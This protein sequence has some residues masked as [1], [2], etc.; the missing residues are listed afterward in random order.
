MQD[1]GSM[2]I[3]PLDLMSAIIKG[4]LDPSNVSSSSSNAAAAV[5]LENRQFLMLLTTSVAVL[6]GCFVVFIWR[7]S[8]SPKAKPLEPPKRVIEKLPEIEVDDG[9]KKVTIFFGTQTGTAEGFAKAIAEE[10]KAR[11]DKAT[12]RVVDMDDY[13]A[14]D[15]EYEERF[16]KET[17]ALFFLATYGDGEPTDNA[18]RFYKWFT[19]GGEKGEGWLENLHYG[20]FGLGNR[21]YE[22][23]NKVAK[24][25]DDMLAEQGGKRLVPV[26]LGDDDQ[27]IEDDFTAWKEELWPALDDLLRDEDDTT[28]STPYT[29]AVLEYRVVIHDPLEASVDEKKWHNVNGHAIVDAQHPVRA[30]VAVR[31]ELHTPASD[32]SCTHLEF[33]IS[34]TG[35]TYET[36]DHVGVYCE[37]LSETV[38]EAI[39]LIGLSP[40]TYFSIHT[41]DEDGK[42]LGGSS[43][44]PTFPPCTLRKALAQYADVLSSPKKSA[45]LALAAHASDPSEAD[46][47]RHLASPAGK[48]EY[49]EW[50]ITSQRSLLEVMAEFPSAKP[51]IGVFFAAVAPRLQPR[52]YSI[53]SSPRMVPNR[54][55]VTCALVHDKMPTGRIHKGVCSTWMKNSVP[56]EKSQ[57]CSWAPIFVRTSNFR[58]PADNKVP[59]IM[60]GPGTGLAPFRGFLQERLALKGGG[61]ELGPSVLFFGC[62]N[63]QMDYIYEDEL[64]HFVNT[65]AL[66]ELILAFSREGPTK[67]YVQHKMMEKA[68]EIWSMIS[69][70][71]YIYVCGDAKGM[72]RDVH[73]ALHTILQEQGSLD[74]SKA[75]SMVKNLQTTGRYLRD[76]W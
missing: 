71:A 49:S 25:V 59:I 63:R 11:Y 40:D 56:L 72:A 61:A 33:D 73:R 60:I 28:V 65:G 29:A 74:S 67:E 9:T 10:A 16:K 47:L 12:F 46:R 3:S 35:V 31:K 39:R 48:D 4:K 58:L 2:K 18:A 13:A 50:V 6:V 7:R 21:Q 1:S 36:G 41:D 30:N 64:N 38:E 57:D 26:G 45:L 76:V 42:P 5:L 15:D 51:P 52:F 23:F 27:C 37:N 75:E 8:S 20:V 43:L 32:R 55:H 19:E 22:H 24:V 53:S 66:S 69:Q 68:S 62:R 34:G 14:D 44:P 54:I 70:G 17:H